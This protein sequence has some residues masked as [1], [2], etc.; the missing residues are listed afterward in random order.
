MKDKE[1][2]VKKAAHKTKLV[3]AFP[4]RPCSLYN[5]VL[6]LTHGNSSEAAEL[7]NMEDGAVLWGT[8][9]YTH[10]AENDS[11]SGAGELHFSSHYL[12]WFNGT[13]SDKRDWT[14]RGEERVDRQTERQDLT[15]KVCRSGEEDAVCLQCKSG[16]SW[17][18]VIVI[19]HTE[20][21]C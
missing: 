5:C 6:L 19:P 3:P 11:H 15:V 9:R 12:A 20:W 4:S 8:V 17:N 14:Q 13:G 21:K 18:S 16:S 2:Q 1:Q 10:R 7:Y